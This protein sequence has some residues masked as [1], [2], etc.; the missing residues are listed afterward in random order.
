M[1][2]YVALA[3]FHHPLSSVIRL[4]RSRSRAPAYA[5]QE[6]LRFD[7]YIRGGASPTV[8]TRQ[9]EKAIRNGDITLREIP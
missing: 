6:E 2:T 3:N 1:S 5:T 7:L 8:L 9:V 4:V